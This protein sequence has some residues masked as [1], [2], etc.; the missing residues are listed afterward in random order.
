[1]R[2]LQ[3]LA[4][5]APGSV[6]V[7]AVLLLTACGDT[8]ATSSVATTSSSIAT[9]LPSAT[10]TGEPTSTQQVMPD[11]MVLNGNGGTRPLVET[12]ALTGEGAPVVEVRWVE[13]EGVLLGIEGARGFIRSVA[14]DGSLMLDRIMQPEGGIR[15]VTHPGDQT[16]VAYYRTCDGNCGLL[17]PESPLCSAFGTLQS[18]K[19]YV[20][21][22]SLR[23]HM[24][25]LTESD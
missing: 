13:T 11:V 14:P 4:R 17:D 19:A 10:S 21:E 24:C 5:S 22:V 2:D 8:A 12:I 16:L 18:G 6:L 9:A 3:P 1:M 20:L 25:S 23:T 15:V 7:G